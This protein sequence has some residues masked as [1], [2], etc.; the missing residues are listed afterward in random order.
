MDSVEVEVRSG[1]LQPDELAFIAAHPEL[2]PEGIQNA[3]YE[4]LNILRPATDFAP[5][6]STKRFKD[7]PENAIDFCLTDGISFEDACKGLKERFGIDTTARSIRSVREKFSR[8]THARPR[9]NREWD[10][11]EVQFCRKNI[12]LP[13]P[14]LVRAFNDAFP[15]RRS[16]S[17]VE[18]HQHSLRAIVACEKTGV[19]TY[20]NWTPEMI[21]YIKNNPD[22][23]ELTVKSVML[24]EFGVKVNPHAVYAIRHRLRAAES[25]PAMA[26]LMELRSTTNSLLDETYEK[27]SDKPDMA[28]IAGALKSATLGANCTALENRLIRV[29]LN[30]L[31]DHLCHGTPLTGW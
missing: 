30:A 13:A 15:G 29:G 6:T 14:E 8:G 23:T 2:S 10:D 11:D 26:E 31:V 17:S 18:S 20:P 4:Q 22:I 7:W 9:S 1:A 25:H 5:G 16:E 19:V 24:R 27:L 12:G 28:K 3:L 21:A